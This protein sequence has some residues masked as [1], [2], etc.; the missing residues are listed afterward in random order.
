MRRIAIV[1]DI[2]YAGPRE[3][4]HGSDFEFAGAPPSFAKS[5]A[6][7]YRNHIWMRNPV[8]NNPLLDHFLEQSGQPD[9]VIANGDYTC[10]V[11]GVGVAHDAALESV[12]LCLGKL[13]ARFGD[14]LH[15]ILG[16][17][18]LGKVSLLGDHGGLRL[19]AWHR[20]THDC[21]LRPFWRVELGNFVLLGVTSTLIGLPMFHADALAAEWPAWEKLRADHLAEIRAAFTALQPHQRVLLFCHDPSA[22]PHLWREETVRAKT[23]QIAHTL[24]GHL[25]TRLLL[26]QTRVLAGLPP[27][28][29]LGVSMQRMTSALSEAKHWRPFNVR[30]CPSLAGIQLLRGGGF[31]TIDLDETATQPPRITLHKIPRKLASPPT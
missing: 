8:G 9:L 26:W 27:V 3:H 29:C 30:L 18:E 1:S 19:P 5:L 24:V 23:G 15:A 2:H 14:R 4:A 25:H 31:L 22:L 12:Q 13:R 10:D 7:L 20:A 6:T 21:G 16:D 17:H 11:A 28:R